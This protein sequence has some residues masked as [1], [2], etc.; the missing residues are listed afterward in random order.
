MAQTSIEHRLSL[1]ARDRDYR[2]ITRVTV[3]TFGVKVNAA[4]GGGVAFAILGLA[5]YDPAAGTSGGDGAAGLKLAFSVLPGALF[6]G[7]A[8]SILAFPLGRRRHDVVRR[9][10]ARRAARGGCRRGSRTFRRAS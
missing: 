6:A 4:I 10:L 7:A 8:L 5:G 3:F 1:L 9:A 2:A